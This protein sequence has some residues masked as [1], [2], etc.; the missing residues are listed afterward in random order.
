MAEPKSQA[1]GDA[2]YPFE[3]SAD[4]IIGSASQAQE[5]IAAVRAF[6]GVI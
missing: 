1:S 2:G 6:S 4:D 5:D 3:A